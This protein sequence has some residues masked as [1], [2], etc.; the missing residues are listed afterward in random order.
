MWL[1]HQ[2]EQPGVLGC[3]PSFEQQLPIP[4]PHLVCHT[5]AFCT[6]AVLCKRSRSTASRAT[7]YY[8]WLLRGETDLSGAD[9]R[10]VV[11]PVS[12]LVKITWWSVCFQINWAVLQFSILWGT[13]GTHHPCVWKLSVFQLGLLYFFL[14]VFSVSTHSLLRHCEVLRDT[15]VLYTRQF[16]FF[17]KQR[18]DAVALVPC[19]TCHLRLII[20]RWFGSLFLERWHHLCLRVMVTVYKHLSNYNIWMKLKS[21]MKFF[22]GDL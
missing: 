3:E 14:F 1:S 13:R 6:C 18:E 17:L 9:K 7:Q 15:V 22:C 20:I 21:W 2:L 16:F 5:D 12:L 10:R 11:W 4:H 8:S 19:D